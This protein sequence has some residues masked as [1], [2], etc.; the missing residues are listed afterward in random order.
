MPSEAI[1]PERLQIDH[2]EVFEHLAN[3]PI[4]EAV[5]QIN[6][7]VQG[8]WD[9]Q[10]TAKAFAAALPEYPTIQSMNAMRVTLDV[11]DPKASAA[12]ATAQRLAPGEVMATQNVQTGWM[13]VRLASADGKQIAV[14]TRDFFAL[15]RLAAYEDWGTFRNEATR[16]WDV[17]VKLGKVEEVARIGCRF[18]NRVEVPLDGLEIRQYFEGFAPPAGGFPFSSFLH[19]DVLTMPGHPYQ[20][21]LIRAHEPALAQSMTLPLILDIEAF[22]AEQSSLESANIPER[23]ADLRWIKNRVFFATV[24]KKLLD[25]CR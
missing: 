3:A 8:V 22:C 10:A 17:F 19:H 18:I 25:R 6:G 9:E 13:G 23:L 16:L 15:S 7:R 2:S 12:D 1:Y 24:T 20:V 4:V 14:F 5:I 21:N 11:Q